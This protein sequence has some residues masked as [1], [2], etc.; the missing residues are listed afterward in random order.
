MM[1]MP[2]WIPPEVAQQQHQQYME[3]QHGQHG[4]EEGQQGEYVDTPQGGDA[5]EYGYQHPQG[6]NNGDHQGPPS[7]HHQEDGSQQQE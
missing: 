3:G 7:P 5:P 6:D 2:G 1:M 4:Y